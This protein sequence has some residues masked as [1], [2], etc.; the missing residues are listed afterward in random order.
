MPLDQ[1]LD[2]EEEGTGGEMSFIGHLEEL[3]WHVI[4]AGGSILVFAILA[5]VYIKEIYHYVLLRLLSLTSGR[6]ECFVS[7]LIKLAMTI[8]VL[9]R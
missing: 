2:N 4:R 1:D 9:N 6:T 3:R 7:L 8:C 5:F